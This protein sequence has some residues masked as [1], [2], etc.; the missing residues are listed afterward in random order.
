MRRKLFPLGPIA[1]AILITA[2][3]YGC[4]GT[5]SPTSPIATPSVSQ[6]VIPTPPAV[7][8]STGI[9]F[10]SASAGENPTG[11]LNVCNSDGSGC[12][13]LANTSPDVHEVAVS[14]D[15][16][17]VAFFTTDR[18]SD[19]LLVAW[20]IR[21]GD[22]LLSV[23]APPETSES[24]FD[25][26]PTRYMAWSPNSSQLAY[27][28]GRDLH[29]VGVGGS[30]GRTL[31]T[32]REARYNLAG[33]I[34]GSIARPVWTTDGTRI[35]YDIFNTPRV[36]SGGADIYRD[37]EYVSLSDETTNVLMENARIASDIAASA[38]E[39]VLKHADGTFFLLSLDTLSVEEL[40]SPAS[41]GLMRCDPTGNLCASVCSDQGELNTINFTAPDG[42]SVHSIGISDLTGE[43][44]AC[45][46]QSVLW[47][48]AGNTLLA[49]VGCEDGHASLWAVETTGWAPTHLTDWEGIGALSLLAWPE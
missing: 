41:C 47:N 27:V 48:A 22:T 6:S 19:G 40:P 31:V 18:D 25:A 32:H 3:A 8:I 49:A 45:T 37:V 35:V 43:A 36:R 20:D 13:V 38:N 17:Y 30:D 24:F 12:R 2:V 39:V 10:Y 15:G 14:P 11:T 9:L 16:K 46:I 42:Q 33:L 29:L 5:P 44:A 7:S 4:G 26:P 1:I 21:S 23:Q 28:L 34:K